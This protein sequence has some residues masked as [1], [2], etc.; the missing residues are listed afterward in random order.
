MK[1][2]EAIQKLK[3]FLD[4]NPKSGVKKISL[5]GEEILAVAN[6]WG[7]A[8]LIIALDHEPD[9][10]IS[11]LN[12]LIFPE[13]LSAIFHVESRRLEVLWTAYALSPNT[14]QVFGREFDFHYNNKV[15]KCGF[16]GASDEL[17]ALSAVIK[18]FG[19]SDNGY[20][21]TLS[22]I[23]YTLSTH[24]DVDL[25]PRFGKP[26]CFYIDDIEYSEDKIIEFLNCLNFFMSYYD[27][28]TPRVI[29][30]PPQIPK[31]PS[32]V[33]TRYRY[34][35]F[36]SVISAR[37]LDPELLQF[38]GATD[39]AEPARKFLYA[40]RII[41]HSAFF[42]VENAPKIAVRKALMMPHA[43]D[44]ISGT[45]DRVLA[46][47]RSST[48]NEYQ[49][50]ESVMA[51]AVDP[52]V[53]WKFI[54]VNVEMFSKT[55]TFDG[56]FEIGALIAGTQSKDDFMNNGVRNI[57]NSARKIRNALAHGRE[58]KNA[59]VILPTRS[60]YEKLRPWSNLI[61]RAAGEIILYE[62]A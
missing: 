60:N 19:S 44:D 37:P 31:A 52:H 53:L 2:A 34:D 24:L 8:A 17:L 26:A 3:P 14:S 4:S 6:P 23:N 56:G 36:P 22:F 50:F 58:D 7:D 27:T 43:L 5:A 10:I 9:D 47:V 57:C 40:Y 15:H 54:E 38:W 18:P 41:E 46:A 1:E 32:E 33:G 62:H 55:E 20:R 48:I 28:L 45:A 13:R 39:T 16:K 35:K 49:R 21:N 59:T 42:F 61:V 30:H 25:D 29:I 11:T 12:K 51:K